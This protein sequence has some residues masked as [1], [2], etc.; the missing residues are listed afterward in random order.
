[1]ARVFILVNVMPGKDRAIR[2]SIRRIKGVLAADV[3]TGHYDIA[4]VLEAA[5][6]SDIFDNILK[7][8][9]AIKGINRTE[10]FVAVE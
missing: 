2:D 6:M 10:T 1:M 9:R 5:A 7:K 4:A 8:V 3:V